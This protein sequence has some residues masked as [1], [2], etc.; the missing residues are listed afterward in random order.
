MT[1]RDDLARLASVVELREPGDRVRGPPPLLEA[2]ELNAVELHR[3]DV[4]EHPREPLLHDLEAGQ[5][6]CVLSALLAVR[7]RCVVGRARVTSRA[8]RAN[9]AGCDEHAPGV[10]ERLGAGEARRL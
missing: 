3:G 6:L 1:E 5:R 8:L 7:E 4:G 9:A 10:L 2:G